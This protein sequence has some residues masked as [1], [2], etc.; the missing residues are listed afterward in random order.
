MF[1]VL[2]YVEQRKIEI[3]KNLNK[4]TQAIIGIKYM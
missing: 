2:D 3:K 4:K 1:F